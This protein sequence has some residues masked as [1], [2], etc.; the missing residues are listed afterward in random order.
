MERAT[1]FLKP[2]STC[3]L[4]VLGVVSGAVVLVLVLVSVLVLALVLFLGLLQ[5]CDGAG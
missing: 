1:T 3:G 4:C 5:L 2:G